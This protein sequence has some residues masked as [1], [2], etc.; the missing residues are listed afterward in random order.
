M[1]EKHEYKG[2]QLNVIINTVA[3]YTE[4]LTIQHDKGLIVTTI[5]HP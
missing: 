4:Q 1:E 2:A 3:C 5:M